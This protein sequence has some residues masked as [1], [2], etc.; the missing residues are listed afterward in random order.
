[1][2][3]NV[4]KAN[5]VHIGAKQISVNTFYFP[6]TAPQ[7]TPNIIGYGLV[8]PALKTESQYVRPQYSRQERFRSIVLTTSTT[9]AGMLPLLFETSLQGQV[10]IPL[11]ISIALYLYCFIRT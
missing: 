9:I 5:P 10:L 3:A 8:S 6:V 1:M 7:V 2:L 4:L 11:V